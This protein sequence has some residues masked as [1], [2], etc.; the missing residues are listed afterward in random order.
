[1][2]KKKLLREKMN[3]RKRDLARVKREKREKQH[4]RKITKEKE[5]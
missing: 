3:D 1:M 5:E 2:K 4:S